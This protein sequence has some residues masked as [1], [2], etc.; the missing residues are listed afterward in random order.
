MPSRSV[1]GSQAGQLALQVDD[2]ISN[3]T[4]FAQSQAQQDVVQ[5]AYDKLY[6]VLGWAKELEGSSDDCAEQLTALEQWLASVENAQVSAQEAQ[7]VCSIEN[8]CIAQH[9]EAMQQVAATMNDIVQSCPWE[10]GATQQEQLAALYEAIKSPLVDLF[11]KFSLDQGIAAEFPEALTPKG[12]YGALLGEPGSAGPQDFEEVGKNLDALCTINEQGKYCIEV[13]ESP[14]WIIA[15]TNQPM[16]CEQAAEWGCCYGLLYNLFAAEDFD[17]FKDPAQDTGSVCDEATGLL[18]IDLVFPPCD[19]NEYPRSTLACPA[20]HYSPTGKGQ[21]GGASS[22]VLVAA[23][24]VAGCALS[25]L[26][27]CF[28]LYK[29]GRVTIRWPA[30]LRVRRGAFNWRTWLTYSREDKSAERDAVSS[31]AIGLAALADLLHPYAGKSSEEVGA[32]APDADDDDDEREPAAA[33]AAPLRGAVGASTPRAAGSR[34]T[35]TERPSD[36]EVFRRA[37]KQA[38]GASD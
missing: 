26:G 2:I 8:S 10:E 4:Q 20:V 9:P 18:C 36:Y 13:Y 15:Q 3:A 37:I 6:W 1:L 7:T 21:T 17:A 33:A 5:C 11:L 24:A 34:A 31:K 30:F 25:L 12:K 16:T 23:A 28:Y 38:R 35:P 19:D 14:F 22:A 32:A 29:T 27:V